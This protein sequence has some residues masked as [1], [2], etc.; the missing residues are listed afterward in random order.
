MKRYPTVSV[1][2]ATYRSFRAK[3]A[4]I[5]RPMRVVLGQILNDSLNN[6]ATVTT[7]CC[8][9]QCRKAQQGKTR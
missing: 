5:G 3:C 6:T 9:H 7:T 4:A 2:G 1:S 8:G